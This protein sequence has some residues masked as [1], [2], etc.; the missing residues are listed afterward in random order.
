MNKITLVTRS[1]DWTVFHHAKFEFL[2]R[3]YFDCVEYDENTIYDKN[4]TLFVTHVIREK[5][6]ARQLH[7]QG[8]KVV[9]DNLVELPAP[10]DYY[11]IYTPNWFWYNQCLTNRAD[12]FNSYVPNKTYTKKAFMPM[13][14]I[15]PHR[16]ALISHLQKHLDDMIY[17]YV[18]KG[19]YLPNDVPHDLNTVSSFQKN[20]NPEWYDQTYFS[21]VAETFTNTTPTVFVTEKTF[22]PIG[23]FHPFL[24]F[25]QTGTLRFLR[26]LG[27]ETFGNLF[28]ES[29]D[30]IEN[31]TERLKALVE[32]FDNFNY[33]EY[34]KLTWD[35]LRH[36]H[37]LLNNTELVID[38]IINE[39]INPLIEYAET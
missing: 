34:D 22:K 1:D 23:F 15:R 11:R 18:Q 8:Y 29:Y 6:W 33:V 20:F 27:F 17:S 14:L 36:N 9:V 7:N 37:N 32:S 12:Q 5:S 10:T 31:Y 21:V 35:K 3:Q 28:D 25:G 38:H 16:D 30:S 2:F 19:I 4:R 24:V 39:V 26:E 13:R